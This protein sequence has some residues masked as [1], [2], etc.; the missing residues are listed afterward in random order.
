MIEES[1]RLEYEMLTK[2]EQVVWRWLAKWNIPFR[3]EV[4]F[5]GGRIEMG[6]TFV[7]FL[8]DEWMIAIRVHGVHWHTGIIPDAKDLYR[9]EMLEEIGYTVVDIWEDQ[10]VNKTASEVDYV[11]RLAIQGVEVPV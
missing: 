8:L 2:P 6:G 3:R 4:P 11:M 7:D 9:R 10:L 1:E 5:F